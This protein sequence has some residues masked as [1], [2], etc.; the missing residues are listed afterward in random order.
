DDERDEQVAVAVLVEE[1]RQLVAVIALDGSF[2]PAL[3]RDPLADRERRVRDLFE[4]GGEVVVTV[5]A[6]WLVGLAEV[7]EQERPPA[8]GVLG[9]AARHVEARGVGL[10]AVSRLLPR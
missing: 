2:A 10:G 3:A 8:A 7:R 4:G 5:P 1:H 9:V 6:R